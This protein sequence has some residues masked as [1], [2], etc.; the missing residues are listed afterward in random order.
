MG[1]GR[2]RGFTLL[3]LLVVIAVIA[4][5]A[6]LLLPVLSR[7][8]AEAR[9]TECKSNLGQLHKALTMYLPVN[10]SQ[11]PRLASRPTLAPNEAR[12]RDVLAPWTGEARVFRCPGDDQK[13]FENE[14]ASY[15]WNALLNGRRQDGPVEQ[16]FGPSRTPMLY[17]YEDFHPKGGSYGGKNVVFSDGSVSH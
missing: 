6:G 13:F 4:L 15:E 16:I 14:G 11:Y 5:L 7:A 1:R 2:R 17:D 10:Q 9:R 8:R 12:L 3:E